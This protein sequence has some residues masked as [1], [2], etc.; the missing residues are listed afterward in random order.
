LRVPIGLAVAP[1]GGDRAVAG[2]GGTGVSIARVLSL[3]SPRQPRL[4]P[5]LMAQSFVAGLLRWP[6]QP[7]LALQHELHNRFG[8]DLRQIWAFTYMRRA[9]LPVLLVVLAVGWALTGVH[10][11]PL[12]G[13]G[14]YER[15]GKPVDVFGPGL[16]AGLPGHWAA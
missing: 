13:R 2:A 3:F 5:R 12:Q 9:F 15:F 7:L 4:E 10:E 11:V 14:I 16:H 1:G 6:P 8:I